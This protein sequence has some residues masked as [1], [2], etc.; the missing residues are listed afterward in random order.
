M[1][2]I[3]KATHTE[4]SNENLNDVIFHFNPY[5]K[6]WRCCNR[7]HQIEMFNGNKNNIIESSSIDVLLGLLNRYGSIKNIKEKLKNGIL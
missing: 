3:L 7:E 1:K 6:L 4:T 2:S 5:N